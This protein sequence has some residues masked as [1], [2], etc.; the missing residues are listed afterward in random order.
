[1]DCKIITYAIIGIFC[2]SFL[3]EDL[4]DPKNY[5]VPDFVIEEK[6]KFYISEKCKGSYLTI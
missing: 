1:M 4:E 5:H 2:Q 3:K 6:D